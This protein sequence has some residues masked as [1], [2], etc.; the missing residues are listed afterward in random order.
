[1]RS[2]LV[3]QRAEDHAAGRAERVAHGDR[4]AVDVDLLHVEAHVLD[5]AQHD[6]RE[7]L[8]DLDQVEVVDREPGLGQRLLGGGRG[9][10][11]HDR[12]VGAG[13]GGGED[14]GARLQ[15]QLLA[16]LL[17]ADR[18][19]RGAVDD[20]RRVAGR[21]DVVDLLDPVVLLQRDGV[22][23]A[24]LAHRGEARLQPG[25]RLDGR[26]GADELV[27]VEHDVLVDVEHRDHRVGELARRSRAAAARSCERAA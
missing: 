24:H 23:A 10:G 15:A 22:E 21:V 11:E 2:Q 19:Q 26:A 8:V 5:E 17:V 4:A 27:V 12:R 16:G 20:A 1:M 9:A 7:R 18:Q 14:P 25:E 3:D 6:R 13:D